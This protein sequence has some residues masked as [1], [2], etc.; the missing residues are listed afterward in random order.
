MFMTI[1]Q[2]HF[3]RKF[4]LNKRLGYWYSCDNDLVRAHRWVWMQYFGE[5]PNGYHIHHKDKDKSNNSIDNL[6]ML[7]ASA[8]HRLHAKEV[9]NDPIKMQKL[10]QH[11]EKIR[12]LASAWHSSEEGK[13][14][15]KNQG[16]QNWI[17]RKFY[18]INCKQCGKQSK[19]NGPH[20]K[21]CSNNCMSQW[22]RVQKIDHIEK[23][24]P[25]CK[26]TYFS[27][28]FSRSKT[29]S[30]SCGNRSRKTLTCNNKIFNGN[31][32]LSNPL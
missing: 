31:L 14:W 26:K 17:N 18:E 21:F 3:G 19:T 20:K 15:H 28:K 16:K 4:Y 6:E 10:R 9:A 30:T 24:C 23:I 11:S 32:S 7:E 2:I 29:C 13:K 12:P 8:H 1:H 22:R 27:S 25:I 5:I